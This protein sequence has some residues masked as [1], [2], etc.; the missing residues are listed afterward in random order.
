MSEKFCLLLYTLID[1]T[2]LKFTEMYLLLSNESIWE[3]AFPT[4][5]LPEDTN[6]DIFLF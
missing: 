5:V 2:E 1:N 4:V 3:C 6:A